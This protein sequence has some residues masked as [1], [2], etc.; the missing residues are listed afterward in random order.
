M[1]SLE[2]KFQQLLDHEKKTIESINSATTPIIYPI[3]MF[4]GFII[5][6]VPQH[7]LDSLDNHIKNMDLGNPN[8]LP[9]NHY[10][11]A[12]NIENQ[13]S[14]PIETDLED[15]VYWLC[16]M[17]MKRFPNFKNSTYYANGIQKEVE[18]K[19]KLYSLWVNFMKKHEFNPPHTHSGRFSFVIWHKIPYDLET[20]MRVSPSQR[21]DKNNLAGVFQFS[22]P[23]FSEAGIGLTNIRADNRYE[24]KICVFPAYLHHAVF[25]F[26]SSN[27]YRISVAGNINFVNGE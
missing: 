9:G 27:E 26:Y 23:T 3:D 12:G 4:N 18:T 19:L 5:D 10:S 16:E 24:G 21:L 25:P 2:I 17:Y 6:K 14:L 13:Y 8:A 20:E 1:N 22:Y 11:L 7:I 15:Y